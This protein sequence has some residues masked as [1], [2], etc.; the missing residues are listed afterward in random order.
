MTD[1]LLVG[2]QNIL[3]DPSDR[4]VWREAALLGFVAKSGGCGFYSMLECLQLS[5]GLEPN[6]YHARP[7]WAWK[8][9]ESAHLHVE[10]L[11]GVRFGADHLSHNIHIGGRNVAKKFQSQMHIPRWHPADECPDLV[12]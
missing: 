4:Q 5:R 7:L 11:I 12:S 2:C 3:S 10:G 9:A 8:G 1:L 6:K